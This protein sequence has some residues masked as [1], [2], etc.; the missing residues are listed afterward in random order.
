MYYLSK[1]GKEEKPWNDV[2]KINSYFDKEK[3]RD[4]SD[5][6]C[7]GEGAVTGEGKEEEGV[8]EEEE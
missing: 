1:S 3:D 6:C 5:L 4:P 7:G 8:E 2:K